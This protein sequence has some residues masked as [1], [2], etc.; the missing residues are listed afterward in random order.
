MHNNNYKCRK[1][2][3][4]YSNDGINPIEPVV[5]TRGSLWHISWADGQF[6]E[7]TGSPQKND[8]VI[9]LILPNEYVEKYFCKV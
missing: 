8:K 3:T 7:F 2:F 9:T 4:T 1:Q 6:K 5:V